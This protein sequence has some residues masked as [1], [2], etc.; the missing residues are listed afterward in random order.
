M[1]DNKNL[2]IREAARQQ[3][4]LFGER[5][6]TLRKNAGLTQQQLA[7]RSGFTASVIARYE[8]GGSLPRPQALEKLAAALG[9]PV[10]DLDG[11]NSNADKIKLV[12]FFNSLHDQKDFRAE[13]KLSGDKV[14]IT[15]PD[16]EGCLE[17][18]LPFEEFYKIMD[19]TEADT[20]A[21]L[22]PWRMLALRMFLRENIYSAI[23]AEMEKDDPEAAAKLKNIMASK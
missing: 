23:M 6:R 19:K 5:L 20:V 17:I 1:K 14:I 7:E 9:V 18:K 13:A 12:N 3:R 8:S 4:L 21:Y 11:S 10:S 22:I 2:N 16:P 15:E